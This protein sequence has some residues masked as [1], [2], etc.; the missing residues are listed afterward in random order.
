MDKKI[1]ETIV[2]CL[3]KFKYKSFS[4]VNIFPKDIYNYQKL[5]KNFGN[6]ID[7]NVTVINDKNFVPENIDFKKVEQK[8]F[9]TKRSEFYQNTTNGIVLWFQNLTNLEGLEAYYPL[10]FVIN[11]DKEKFLDTFEKDLGNWNYTYLTEANTMFLVNKNI[12][13]FESFSFT[14]FKISKE[15][16]IVKP[17]PVYI[18]KANTP[19]FEVFKNLPRPTIYPPDKENPKWC[20]EF[21]NYLLAL[22]KIIVPENRVNLIPY[23]LNKETLKIFL[24]AFTHYITDVNNIKNYEALETIGDT[25]M[26]TAFSVYFFERNP[27]ADPDLLKNVVEETQSDEEQGRFSHELGIINWVQLDDVLKDNSKIKEDLLEAFG[28]AIELTLNKRGIYGLSEEIFVNMFKIIYDNYEFKQVKDPKTWLMQLIDQ[29]RP[30]S[31]AKR[32]FSID[33]EKNIYMPRPQDIDEK[34]FQKIVDYAN[35]LVTEEDVSK[36][37]V[38]KK[39]E[40]KEKDE[41]E[42]KG[43]DVREYYDTDK[44]KYIAE[45]F[46]DD[47]GVKVLKYYGFNFKRNQI[48]GKAIEATKK[49]ASRHAGEKAREYLNNLGINNEWIKEQKS[50]KLIEDNAPLGKEALL[51]AKSYNKKIIKLGIKNKTLKSDAVYVLYGEDDKGQRYILQKYVTTDTRSK[52]VQNILFE[53]YLNS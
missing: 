1:S 44:H 30:A 12:R 14:D 20:Q 3:D 50:R 52:F 9:D 27:D 7:I 38:T 21:Y 39:K 53:T 36:K 19:N 34:L 18:K 16:K 49:P 11:V 23:I 5:I 43:I 47:Y 46:I 2:K 8:Y 42:D 24:R 37:I 32:K 45:F 25:V 10:I 41:G 51:K 29:I 48:L 40:N 6:K 13:G 15:P 33:K 4:L 35:K 28:G 22:L 26:K 31:I 17:K